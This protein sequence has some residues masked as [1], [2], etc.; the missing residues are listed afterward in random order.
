MTATQS[1]SGTKPVREPVNSRHVDTQLRA[2]FEREATTESDPEGARINGVES[3]NPAA[4]AGL[5]HGALVTKVDDQ[6]IQSAGALYAAAPSRATGVRMSVRFIDC[7]VIPE[8]FSSASA[9]TMASRELSSPTW[10]RA[11]SAR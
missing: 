6:V 5:A 9:P 3:D 11:T 7:V 2:R 4:E 10:G 1:H 8:P